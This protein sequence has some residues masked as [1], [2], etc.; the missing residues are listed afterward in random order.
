MPTVS[1]LETQARRLEEAGDAVEALSIYRDLLRQFGE[2]A[3]SA[4]DRPALYTR[5][6]DLHVELHEPASAFGSYQQAA[7]QYAR[8][9]S[10][11][12]IKKLCIRMIN[13]VPAAG[14]SYALYARRLYEHRHVESALDVLR[15]YA[16]KAGLDTVSDAV[17]ALAGRSSEEMRPRIMELL[18]AIDQDRRGQALVAER[19][20]AESRTAAPTADAELQERGTTPPVREETPSVT[21]SPPM[22]RVSTTSERAVEPERPVAEPRREVSQ[23]QKQWSAKDRTGW[24]QPRLITPRRSPARGYGGRR[25]HRMRAVARYRLKYVG[26]A[27]G[28]VA[29][30]GLIAIVSIRNGGGG[31]S[32]PPVAVAASIDTSSVAIDPEPPNVVSDQDPTGTAASPA[33]EPATDP[34]PVQP[35]PVVSDTPTPQ[36]L[37]DTTAPSLTANTAGDSADSG[38]VI[39]EPIIV[40]SA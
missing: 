33:I 17:N 30:V 10:A 12:D 2:S 18:N 34:T 27:I 22:D 31:N 13:V 38:S 36:P 7:E 24:P 11:E 19:V 29:V 1:E 28:I 35:A 8:L 39:T 37:T 3:V 25:T 16:S 23:P 4:D 5:V 32:P 26:G 40:G 20:S 9:G 14:D 15:E 21:E 6:G